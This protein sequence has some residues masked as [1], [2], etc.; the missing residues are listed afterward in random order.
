MSHHCIMTP[1]IRGHQ[2]TYIYH[3]MSGAQRLTA[4]EPTQMLGASV[5]FGD[6]LDEGGGPSGNPAD[7]GSRP[8][9]QAFVGQPE[10]VGHAVADTPHQAGRTAQDLQRS[11]H[12]T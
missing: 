1:G 9:R 7:E 12:P 2:V 6:M 5:T 3:N 10:E 4:V 11:H 8:A